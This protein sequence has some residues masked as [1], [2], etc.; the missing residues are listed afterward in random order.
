MSKATETADKAI[1]ATIIAAIAVLFTGCMF[2]S[3][4]A[5]VQKP[6]VVSTSVTS[7]AAT[8]TSAVFNTTASGGVFAK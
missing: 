6:A 2:A 3:A 1:S 8:T 7:H 4:A 5:P